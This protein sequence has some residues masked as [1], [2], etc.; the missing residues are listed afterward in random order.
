MLLYLAYHACSSTSI[1]CKLSKQIKVQA[2][3]NVCSGLYNGDLYNLPAEI[4]HHMHPLHVVHM[5][6]RYGKVIISVLL[7]NE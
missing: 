1:K 5:Q 4:K 6:P 3:Y 2:T 7:W